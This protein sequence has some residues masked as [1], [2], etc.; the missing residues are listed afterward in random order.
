MDLNNY[1]FRPGTHRDKNVIWIHFSYSEKLKS[2]LKT[3][4]PSAKWSRTQKAWHLPDIPSVRK[5]LNIQPDSI[6]RKYLNTIHPVNREQLKKYIQQ[7]QLKAY[8]QNTIKVYVSEFSNLLFLLKAYPVNELTPE[9]LKSYFLYCIEKEKVKEQNL[10][11]KI[12]AIK[13]YFEKVLHRP[14]MFFDI[15]RPK[16]PQT[17]PK[18]LSKKEILKIFEPLQ[19]NSKHLFMLQLCYGMGLRVSEVV[20]LKMNQIDIDRMQ[21]LI[22]AGK[23]KKDRYVN[24]PESVLPLFH[25]YCREYNPKDWLFQGQYGGQYSKG[26][27]Q[28]VFKRAMKNAGI[29]KT[30]GIHGLRHSYATHLLEAGADLRFI[31]ELLGHNSIKTTQIYT[32]VAQT[33]IAKIKSPLDQLN[34]I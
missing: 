6:E 34:N 2:A 16:T 33:S 7:L 14:K 9:R 15:P 8:S 1:S 19:K 30:I 22:K 28:K 18:M 11:G 24:L 20:G 21:V 17:L 31:Q 23:G 27:V 32:H 13:F 4:F 25:N 3:R 26:S 10:N 29:K 5:A 12:N